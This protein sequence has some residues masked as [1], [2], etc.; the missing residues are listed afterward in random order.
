[1][2]GRFVTPGVL[3]F[4]SLLAA[5]CGDG[6]GDGAHPGMDTWIDDALDPGMDPGPGTR[7]IPPYRRT[8]WDP[9]VRGGIAPVST[10]CP[11]GA[12]SV[13][14]HGAAGDGVTDDA[15]A[16]QAAIEAVEDGGAV[17]IP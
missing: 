16:F 4:L 7:I 12:V 5:G 9:G 13:T 1:M 11:A 14:D 6:D 2:G 8:L 15:A 3:V 17:R 10:V